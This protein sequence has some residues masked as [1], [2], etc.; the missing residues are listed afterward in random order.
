M[1]S[2]FMFFS[3]TSAAEF[4]ERLRSLLTLSYPLVLG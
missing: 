4:L 3:L 2:Y 1:S